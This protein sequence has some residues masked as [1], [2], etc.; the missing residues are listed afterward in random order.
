MLTTTADGRMATATRQQKILLLDSDRPSHGRRLRSEPR[1][2][3]SMS[4]IAIYRQLSY[5]ERNPERPFCECEDWEVCAI[6]Q[7]APIHAS[8]P[9]L[10][11][12]FFLTSASRKLTLQPN[13]LSEEQFPSA[14]KCSTPRDERLSSW[15]EPKGARIQTSRT[16]A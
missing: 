16:L 1:S 7:P 5:H 13:R 6:L 12:N 8:G 14:R 15:I 9:I 10:L 11:L 2:A 4:E 3:G